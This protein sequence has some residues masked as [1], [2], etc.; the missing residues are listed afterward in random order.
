MPPLPARVR[1]LLASLAAL[2]AVWAAATWLTGGGVMHL[3]ALRL[4]SRSALRPALAA[5]LLAAL[6]LYGSRAESRRAALARVRRRAD[7]AAPWLA[8]VAAMAV[9]TTAAIFGELAASGADASGYLHQ[10]QLWAEGRSAL[11]APVLDDGPW[12][13]AGWEVAPLG[14]APSA[15]PGLLGPTYA[16]G[17]P[18]LMTLGHTIAGAPG[19]FVWTPLAVGAL[20]WLTFVLARREMPPAAALGAVLLVAT[21]PPLLF[22]A[23]QTM[24]DL[25]GAALWTAAIVAL[26]GHTCGR[27]WQA[28][29]A[30]AIALAVRPNLVLV[31]ASVW[32]AATVTAEGDRAAKLRHGARLAL[33][34]AVA[35]ALVAWINLR[36][37][38]SPF[39]SGY[40][41]TGDL[42]LGENIAPNL[43]RLW[44]W[45]R[46]TRAWWMLAALP[47]A[48]ALVISAPR[49]RAWLAI[50]LVAGI[51]ASYLPY[52]V[53]AE[54]WY[55][56]FYLP[57]WPV[58]ATATLALAWRL[59]HRASPDAAPL[60]VLAV[61]V[62]IAGPAV[63][64][65]A[66]QGVFELWRGAQRYPAVATWVRANA[67]AHAVLWSVQHSGA[68]AAHGAATV[69]RWDY[70]A[71]DSLDARVAT[72]AARGRASWV[73][74]DDW[75]EAVW[76]QRFAS[77][78]RG[79]LDWAPL[80]EA[81]VGTTR[82][83]VF[84]LTA[85]TRAVAPALIR[86]VHG[87]PWPPARRPGGAGLEVRSLP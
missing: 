33:P 28:G 7:A 82:V 15:T 64:H 79:R 18:W 70:I 17:L 45:T 58:L 60:A 81:R 3:G 59:L 20:A 83:H 35:A 14:F 65:A 39:A 53:F 30:A 19:R 71:P 62:V 22:A 52:A 21:S 37:W 87:G 84:D 26:G 85:P 2:A 57:A 16:P 29:L 56:R 24:S 66:G 80:A 40:G 69:A 42:F 36:L 5:L 9:A 4:S 77:Q 51:L 13:G 73:V 49:R 44:Q 43:G 1:S 10:S 25:P 31:A 75:E 6:A 76:R 8:A 61:A 86:V 27:V 47:A 41:A 74:L 34:I 78:V 50:A 46:E 72:L 54:W 68:L 48:A 11:V 32:T 55:L 38:G 67:P 63:R 23:T 12:P